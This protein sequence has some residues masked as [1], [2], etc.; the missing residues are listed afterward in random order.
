MIEVSRTGPRYNVNMLICAF[1]FWEALTNT[2]QL[3]CGMIT[4][5]LFNVVAITSLR[6]IGKTFESSLKKNI[7]PNF[8][9]EHPSFNAYIKDHHDQIEEVYDYEHISFLT[10]WL[11]HFIFYSSSLQVAKKFVPLAT[12]LYVG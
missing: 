4:L 2:F 11:S 12:Q 6:P 8:S 10:L 1:Y 5:T 9:F 7:K 3:P